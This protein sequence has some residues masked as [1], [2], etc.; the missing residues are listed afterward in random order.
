MNNLHRIFWLTG[1][2]AVGLAPVAQAEMS[3]VVVVTPAGETA[4]ADVANEA[5][6]APATTVEEWVSQMAAQETVAANPTE[7]AQALTQITGGDCEH[8]GRSP[9]AGFG[10]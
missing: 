4:T 9:G 6:V 5:D 2:F 8:G 1:L 7:V 10:G 3:E